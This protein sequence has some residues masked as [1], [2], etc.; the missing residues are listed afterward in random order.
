MSRERGR[1]SIP[2]IFGKFP[3]IIF[4]HWEAVSSSRLMVSGFFV[5]SSGIISGSLCDDVVIILESCWDNF[6]I[7]LES[8]WDALG[9]S[10]G[11]F[12][13]KFEAIGA[14]GEKI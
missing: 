4:E 9:M 10:L 11:S 2:R 13:G 5:G 7:I 14:G 12:G 3:K 6:G 8:C 1:G